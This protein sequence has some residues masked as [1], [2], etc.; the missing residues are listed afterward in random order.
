[1]KNKS[2]DSILFLGK[3]DDEY[4][5]RAL[6]FIEANFENVVAYFSA[7]GEPMPEEIKAWKGDYILSYL[8]RWVVPASVIQSAR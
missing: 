4:C 3:K 7:W 1:M 2:T 8:C 5:N 6:K